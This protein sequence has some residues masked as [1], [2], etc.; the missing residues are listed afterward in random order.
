ME[1]WSTN[2]SRV[3]RRISR[4]EYERHDTIWT[5]EVAGEGNYVA[6][7]L[8]SAN[9]G[10]S[11]SASLMLAYAIY[12]LSCLREPQTYLSS[13]PGVQLSSDAD[14]V[15]MNASAAGA[16]QAAKV[17][18]SEVQDK[19]DASPYFKRYFPSDRK[20]GTEMEWWD[21]GV[22]FAAGN[23]QAR[24]ALGWN[25]YAFCVDEAA[26][27][28]QNEHKDTVRDLFLALN[29]RRRSRFSRMG[30]G[31]LFTSPGAESSFVEIMAADGDLAG[32]DVMVR[33]TTTW[34]AKNELVPG[35]RVFL[36]DSDPNH[37]VVLETDL[38]WVSPGVARRDDGTIVRFGTHIA[39]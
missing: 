16:D 7:G 36:L 4:I 39:A 6:D 5:C 1:A 29:Q 2:D 13:F 27:G 20:T 38:E 32:S 9:S 31:G 25:V 3:V 8:V 26:F 28:T 24:S 14:I 23:S 33:R 35:A 11:F 17:V 15:V 19:I 21:A 22:R 10:K 30:M 37:P 34:E 18:Y 12:Q